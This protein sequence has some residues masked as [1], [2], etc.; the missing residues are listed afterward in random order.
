MD[1]YGHQWHFGVPLVPLENLWIPSMIDQLKCRTCMNMPATWLL[2]LT[3]FNHDFPLSTIWLSLPAF[4]TGNHFSIHGQYQVI[5]TLLTIGDHGL[6]PDSTVLPTAI[7]R[8]QALPTMILSIMNRQ[9]PA[10]SINHQ[11]S[12]V[13]SRLLLVLTLYSSSFHDRALT[14]NHDKLSHR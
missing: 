5:R 13:I 14:T 1:H 2:I 3:R 4:S 7:K 12:L 10:A 9:Q 11:K 6:D 8:D